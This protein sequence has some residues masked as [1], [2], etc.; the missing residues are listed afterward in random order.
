[1]IL[2]TRNRAGLLP[3]AIA[4][5]LNQSRRDLEL[6]IVDDAS[7]DGTQELVAALQDPRVVLVCN[8]QPRGDAAA[9]NIG[10]TH[11]R[12]TWLA[13][14]DSDDEWVPHKLAHQPAIAAGSGD[15][16]ALIGS[17]L[18]RVAGATVEPIFWPVPADAPEPAPVDRAR[19]V[20]GFCAYLQSV[21]VRRSAF[22]AAGGFDVAL[23]ARSDFDLCLR[24]LER[25]RLVATREIVALSYETPDGISLKPEFRR[26]DIRHMLRKH[27]ATLHAD[28]RACARYTYELAR[29]E[30]LCGARAAAARA[31]W[32]ALRHDPRELRALPL[33]MAAPF[34]SAG[35]A[36]LVRLRRAVT[37]GGR[38]HAAR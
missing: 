6:V 32:Q 27:A 35:L 9:R 20:A 33:L 7:T 14:Q 22:D 30:L 5:V 23:K 21:L 17:G 4:S 1:V 13:F 15:D 10:V 34:G 12:G 11:A 26:D 24:L 8:E 25:Q 2:P 38:G 37:P 28:P 18:L 29:T 36:G 3:R 19:F 31:A 16:V